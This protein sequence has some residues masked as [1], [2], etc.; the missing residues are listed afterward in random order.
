[1]IIPGKYQAKPISGKFSQSNEKKTPCIAI[2]LEFEDKNKAIHILPWVGWLSPAAIERTCETLAI[3]GFDD[4]KGN[5]ADGNVN[6]GSFDPFATVEITVED[7]HFTTKD[8]AQ[9]TKSVIKWVN[10]QGGS[11]FVT[12]APQEI[13]NMLA[14][15][16]IKG[17]MA[18][19]KAKLNI[20]TTKKPFNHAPGAKN[21]PPA[22]RSPED[23]EEIPF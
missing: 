8:G 16:N 3:M 7:E 22:P 9:K 11:Q 23:M 14:S 10:K 6:A 15:V 13:S 4:S 19:A 5:D 20:S 21:A 1:M 17:Q 2:H 12:L 18:A